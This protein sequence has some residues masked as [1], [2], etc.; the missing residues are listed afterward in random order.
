MMIRKAYIIFIGSVLWT[1]SSSFVIQASLRH[2][3]LLLSFMQLLMN[4]EEPLLPG[5]CPECSDVN[6]YWDGDENFVCVSCGHEWRVD[7]PALLDSSSDGLNSCTD[8]VGNQIKTG[9]TVILV[10]ELGKGLKKGLKIARIRV[11]DYDDGHNCQANIPGLGTYYLKS[12]FLKK[13]K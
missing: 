4:S 5:A 3:S 13:A 1:L 9:D 12:A 7:S 8:S 10:K 2:G 6:G 11:G